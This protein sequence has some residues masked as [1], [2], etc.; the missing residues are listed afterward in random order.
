MGFHSG[1]FLIDQGGVVETL[2]KGEETFCL[3]VCLSVSYNPIIN[4]I[5]CFNWQ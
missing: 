3:N 5:F 4:D 2:E 1:S